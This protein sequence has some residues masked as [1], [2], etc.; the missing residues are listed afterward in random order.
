VARG[1]SA[2]AGERERETLSAEGVEEKRPGRGVLLLSRGVPRP[3]AIGGVAMATS[4]GRVRG[5]SFFD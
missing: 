2:R 3:N 4:G 5:T 1:V